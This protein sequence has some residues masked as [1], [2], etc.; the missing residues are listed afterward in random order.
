MQYIFLI[1]C[2][3]QAFEYG[4]IPTHVIVKV[5][6]GYNYAV[7]NSIN[8]A[9]NKGYFMVTNTA[10]DN[11][12][13]VHASIRKTDDVVGYNFVISIY[14][15]YLYDNDIMCILHSLQELHNSFI[16]IEL[17][18]ETYFILINKTVTHKELISINKNKNM[19]VEFYNKTHSGIRWH[20]HENYYTST[21]IDV[22][23]DETPSFL[24]VY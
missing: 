12:P 19:F 17:S 11:I 8:C 7:F 5:N 18:D 3:V 24:D 20:D 1:L 4:H 21:R 23:C 2:L 6:V 22:E 9:G 10:D 15:N 13:V 16:V 14:S